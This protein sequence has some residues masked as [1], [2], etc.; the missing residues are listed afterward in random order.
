MRTLLS[1]KQISAEDT[2][3]WVHHDNLFRFS[4]FPCRL[5]EIFE[6]TTENKFEYT[7]VFNEYTSLIEGLL[8]KKLSERIEGFSMAEFEE[9]LAARTG[10]SFCKTFIMFMSTM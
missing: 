2:A 1:N 3:V 4:L 7:A 8:E 10:T 9:M 6:D 5:A